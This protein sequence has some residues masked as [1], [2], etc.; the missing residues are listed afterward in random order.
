MNSCDT[1]RPIRRRRASRALA[2][3]LSAAV[4]AGAMPAA[5]DEYELGPQDRIRLKIYEWRPSHDTIFEWT[6]LNDQFTVAADGTL[7]L[8]FI[9]EIRA[10]GTLQGDLA[11]TIAE[12]LRNQMGLGRAP[13]VAVEIVQYRPF[14][15]VGQVV[16]PGEFPYR[17]G[18][19]VL[20]AVS[21]GGGLKSS[22]ET[23]SRLERE[24]I[25]V[26]GDLDLLSLSQIGLEARRAR[27]QAELE[28]APEIAFS[29]QLSALG[30]EPSIRMLMDQ[31]Q[32][33]F[34]ARRDGL[35]TQVR[36]LTELEAF[37]KEELTAL[38]GQM[39]YYDKQIALVEKELSGVSALV[40][41]GLAVAPR[42]IS[43]ERSLTQAQ[44]ERLSASTSLMRARQEISRTQLAIL[45]LRNSRR[46]EV[47]VALRDTQAQLD[48]LASRADT[49]VQLLHDSEVTAPRLLAL[50]RQTERA[51]PTYTILRPGTEGTTEIPAEESTALEPGDTVKVELP[52]P[53]YERL[54]LMSRTPGA[55]QGPDPISPSLTG[56]I[57]AADRARP[58][59]TN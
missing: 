57:A 6:A 30:Q 36:A 49:T 48:E 43:L 53:D 28:D 39:V 54:D 58:A 37:L 44:S 18:L 20:Q 23:A 46:N 10:E 52:L 42:E 1:A 38:E 14:Y 56:G 5:A 9:G 25:A 34:E 17:P 27:L 8:P 11:R 12:R 31:E 29:E 35:A 13:D 32:L 15:I 45:E 50:R 2:L 24:V 59:S 47:T 55:L 21:I 22:E 4:L 41:K 3:A 33:I 7:F 40:S 26:R 16:Q 51:E 19:T